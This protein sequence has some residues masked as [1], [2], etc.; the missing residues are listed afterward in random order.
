V[1][2]R[3]KRGV[4]NF[5]E[6][7]WMKVKSSARSAT[8]K[9]K[10]SPTKLRLGLPKGSLQDATIE[11]MAKAGFNVQISSR[12][13]IP[14]V[15]DEEMEIRLIRAQEISRYVEHGYLDCGITGHDW[16]RENGSD[17]HEVG[18]FVFSK[19]SRQPTRWVLAVPEDSSIKSVK[20]L[21]GKRIATEVVNLTNSYLKKNGVKAEV[22]FSWGATEVKAHELVDAIVEVTETGSSLRANNL[23]IVDTLL[24]ST[25]RL[26]VNHDSWKDSWKR[27]KIE[28]LALLLRGALEAEAKVG[29]KMNIEQSRLANLLKTLPALRNPTIAQLSL[30]GWVAVETI[31]DEHIVREIIPQL[32]AAGA[33]GIIE[34]PLNKVVY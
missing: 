33:E 15:D 13:Y 17:V 11:K 4:K 19:V 3:R 23:R 28:T 10:A 25:P 32:K 2:A 27:K 18:E 31:I 34:Y 7:S 22:E 1:V 29:L 6:K 14:Y 24:T 30:P 5:S 21:Q 16:V 20:D 12:S 8:K 26:I 9:F